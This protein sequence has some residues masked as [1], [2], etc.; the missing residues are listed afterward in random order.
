MAQITGLKERQTAL[1]NIESKLK[2]LETLNLFL[3][4]NNPTNE[5]VIKFD[6]I[7]VSLFNENKKDI[8]ALVSASKDK[9]VHEIHE[10]SEKYSITLDEED[11][12]I[13]NELHVST[14]KLNKLSK[15]D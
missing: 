4:T 8:D 11:T 14:R 10:L 3:Q 15:S 9:I 2:A 12:K 1:I 5:Y 13:I 6:K 7:K